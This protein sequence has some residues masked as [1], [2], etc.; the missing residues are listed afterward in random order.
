MFSQTPREFR[1]TMR[2]PTLTQAEKNERSRLETKSRPHKAHP[3]ETIQ[4]DKLNPAARN[5]DRKQT[6]DTQ[7]KNKEHRRTKAWQKQTTRQLKQKTRKRT[8]KSHKHGKTKSTT[9]SKEEIQTRHKKS[10][11]SIKIRKRTDNNHEIIQETLL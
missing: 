6:K 1:G 10:N 3:P 7:E 2:T 5:H 4:T 9:K 8:T 11:K